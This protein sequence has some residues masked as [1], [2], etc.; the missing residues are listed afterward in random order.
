MAF[1]ISA[2]SNRFRS[3]ETT[4][5]NNKVKSNKENGNSR[6]YS[7]SQSCDPARKMQTEAHISNNNYFVLLS[8]LIFVNIVFI[9]I[10]TH[11]CDVCIVFMD[12]LRNYR[13][14]NEIDGCCFVCLLHELSII[15]SLAHLKLNASQTKAETERHGRYDRRTCNGNA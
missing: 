7:R 13:Q 8:S 14:R 2:G 5:I 3:C 11:S 15:H 4:A 10:Q 6:S 9:Y 1:G 12:F